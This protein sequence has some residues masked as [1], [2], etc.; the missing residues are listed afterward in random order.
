MPSGFDV[1][2]FKRT[3]DVW[4]RG[5]LEEPKRRGPFFIQQVVRL[6]AVRE[7]NLAAQ[8]L[9]E[10]A[11][12]ILSDRYGVK[13][14]WRYALRSVQDSVVGDT[15]QTLWL[16][17]GG[18]CLVLLIAVLNVSNLLLARGTARGRELAVR[19]SLG[20]GRARLAR[21]LLVESALLGLGGGL[22]GLG[23]AVIG[24]RLAR[25][26]A[27]EIVPR[28]DEVQLSVPVVLFALAVGVGAGL[29]ARPR[30]GAPSSV[31]QTVGSFA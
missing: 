3:S 24:L 30:S 12:P 13:P 14:D 16:A 7:P 19:A 2:R 17:F 23:I 10:L 15:R 26:A 18:V 5:R 6:D 22:L 28:M 20:A 1:P 25:N 11:T 27:L 21:Q 9:T 4:V 8:R 31:G 29:L